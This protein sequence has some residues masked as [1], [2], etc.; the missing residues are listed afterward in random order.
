MI[1][2]PNEPPLPLPPRWN[3]GG[4]IKDWT[5]EPAAPDFAP[6]E[7]L[8]P[9]PARPHP[10]GLFRPG[11][12]GHLEVDAGGLG[13]AVS[14]EIGWYDLSEQRGGF[15]PPRADYHG[16]PIARMPDVKPHPQPDP[17]LLRLTAVLQPPLETLTAPHGVLDWP[18]PLL[19]F[20]REGI[21]ALLSR[22]ELLLADDMG[23]GKTIMA[24]A[25]LRILYFRREIELALVV[26]PASLLT[27]WQRELA[28]WAPELRVAALSGG[29]GGRG[30]LWR[31]P[32]HVRLVSYETLRADVLGLRDSPVL[33]RR[34]SVVVLDEASRIK[35]RESALAIACKRVP[36]DR[37]WAL[38][39]TPL[40][41]RLEDL[42]SLFEFLHDEPD[43]RPRP[44][45]APR[46]LR[47][48]LRRVQLRRKK[49]DVLKDLPPKQVNEL[50]IELTPAQ[51]AAYERAEQEGVVSL[52]QAGAN[53]TVTHVLE[54]IARLKQLCNCDPASGES[55]KLEDIRQRLGTL[56]E[57][58]H[59]ALVFSQ[60]TDETFG[61]GRAAAWLREFRPLQFTGSMTAARRAAVVDQF[62][63]DPR[64]KALILSVRA[65]GVGLNLQAASYVFHLD[66]WW[67][68]AIEDQA[69]SRAHRMGQPYP[70]TI[71]RYV[72][73]G[74][75][76]ERIDAKLREKRR[77]FQ[78][79]VDDVSLDISTAL[80]E[81][82]IF[83]LFGLAAPR[84]AAASV[85]HEPAPG[86]TSRT[87]DLVQIRF[88][89][90]TGREFEEWVAAQLRRLGF[91]VELTPAGKDGGID[92]IA[93]RS[94]TLGVETWLLVQC[95]NHRE[96]VGVSVVRELRGVAPDRS[97]GVTAVV[98]CPGGFTS[99]ASAFAADRG[100]LLWGLEELREL[101]RQAKG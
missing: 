100:V 47:D 49:E 41:N 71:F 81:E 65:G 86:V 56:V 68:P 40:E 39:G 80:S 83:G 34:W 3:F 10:T 19:D 31:V 21:A 58:G 70:V 63:S 77:L 48:R 23:L 5:P 64:H 27:Q 54:L 76:E 33:R 94:D 7:P 93:S 60:F 14:Y 99:E 50:A 6:V 35:N 85:V 101:E 1:P 36:R 95:K 90:M 74:T 96:P 37:C 87:Y 57:E 75:V 55:A 2:H 17:L 59:R 29:A 24:I 12:P 30:S 66:R 73:A 4:L 92:L 11:R 69:D 9:G 8:T 79:I 53:V 45:P 32:A 38:T 18:A 22:W 82:E 89:D 25:A 13:R 20:Q 51:Q 26:C 15:L 43:A 78:D 42:A 44:V 46:A 52:A 72:C 16:P 88:R 98:V 91:G 97:S 84:P 28:R 61:V 67:N 62:V